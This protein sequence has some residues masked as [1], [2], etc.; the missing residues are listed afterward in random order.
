M[1]AACA[2]DDAVVITTAYAVLAVVYPFLPL[3]SASI[4]WPDR[5]LV[6]VAALS[7]Q[8]LVVLALE[9]LSATNSS[10]L[11][12]IPFVMPS[13]PQSITAIVAAT[14]SNGIG[15]NGGLPWRLP[16]E[17]KYF[18]RGEWGPAHPY[19]GFTYATTR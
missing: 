3:T 15:L 1:L 18:A 16:G 6:L 4:V 5:E 17:M 14:L 9:V 7:L 8:L 13:S 12:P 10:V 11:A 19:Q 2:R